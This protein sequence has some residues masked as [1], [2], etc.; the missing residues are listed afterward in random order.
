MIPTKFNDFINSP[1][2]M[3]MGTRDAQLVPEVSRVLGARFMDENH[4]K[5]FMDEPTNR[6]ALENLRENGLMSLVLV[7]VISAFSYQ[8]KGRLVSS[9]P[10]TQEEL[11]EFAH[12][13]AGFNDA[14]AALWRM[15]GVPYRYP[16]SSM[17]CL[18]ME[19]EE[20][21]EQTP[22]KGTGTKVL[23]T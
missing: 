9:A 17:L 2:G 22:R 16:H 19:V 20:I 6:K 7:D 15:P 1:H 12:Y 8:F 14:I 21:F 13:M 18:V 10:M 5:C 23:T 4:I 11:D 3:M